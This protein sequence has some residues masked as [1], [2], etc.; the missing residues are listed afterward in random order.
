MKTLTT[1]NEV[2]NFLTTSGTIVLKAGATWCG[3]C[4]QIE[5]ILTEL[6]EP[7]FPDV[8]FADFDIEECPETV[9]KFQIRN[10]PMLFIFKDGQLIDTNVGS[11][12]ADILKEKISNCL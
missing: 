11:A 2:C 6:V 3:P 4:K 1:D 9:D 12:S 10:V 5:K 7:E 8:M